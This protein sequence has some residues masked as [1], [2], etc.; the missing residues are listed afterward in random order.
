[1]IAEKGISEFIEAAFFINS[2]YP[3]TEFILAGDIDLGNPSS[4][5]HK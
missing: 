4:Y 1:M 2:K 3:K 5:S